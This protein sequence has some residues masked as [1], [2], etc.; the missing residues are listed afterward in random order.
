VCTVFS[1]ELG[2]GNWKEASITA[3]EKIKCVTLI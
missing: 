3:W 1:E 2:V